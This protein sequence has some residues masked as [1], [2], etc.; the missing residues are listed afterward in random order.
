MPVAFLKPACA[1]VSRAGIHCFPNLLMFIQFLLVEKVQTDVP[2]YRRQQ[3]VQTYA[4]TLVGVCTMCFPA[5]L[6]S[7][8]DCHMHDHTTETLLLPS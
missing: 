5:C 7:G 4:Q 2:S 8:V 3:A 1:V 6:V